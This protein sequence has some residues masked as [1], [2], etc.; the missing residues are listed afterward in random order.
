MFGFA[1]L[2]EV[3]KQLEHRGLVKT[4]YNDKH[5]YVV[6]PLKSAITRDLQAYPKETNWLRKDVWDAFIC[7]MPAGPRFIDAKSGEVV[8]GQSKPPSTSEDWKPVD[9]LERNTQQEWAWDFLRNHNLSRE[10]NLADAGCHGK[11]YIDFGG[12]VAEKERRLRSAWN[13][14]RTDKTTEHVRRWCQEQGV[15]EALLFVRPESRVHPEPETGT[16]LRSTILR[17]LAKMKT[18]ELLE[19]RV[20]LKYV[21]QYLPGDETCSSNDA[22]QDS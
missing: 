21:A 7:E 22:P 15:R 12:A 4:D 3:L 2:K 16:A 1:T 19:L 13:R 14:T 17:T 10:Q 18:E 6:R 9:R 5:A 11:W 8:M 20:P